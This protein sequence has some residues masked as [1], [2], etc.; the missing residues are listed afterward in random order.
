MSKN[1]ALKVCVLVAISSAT[2]VASQPA[3]AAPI[4]GDKCAEVGGNCSG[5]SCFQDPIFEK[6]VKKVVKTDI[7][8]YGTRGSTSATITCGKAVHCANW[9]DA[10]SEPDCTAGN[11]QGDPVAHRETSCVAETRVGGASCASLVEGSS[12]W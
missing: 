5:T 2:L 3:F 7:F 6:W 4:V 11:W 1:L 12:Q 10:A 9:R 8:I